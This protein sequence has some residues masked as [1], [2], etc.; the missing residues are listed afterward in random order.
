MPK[1]KTPEIPEIDLISMAI[2]YR[3]QGHDYI[4]I[5]EAMSADTENVGRKITVEYATELV[6]KGLNALYRE[7]AK[8]AIL[9]DLQRVNQMMTTAY[10][11]AAQGESHS[12][13][14]MLKLMDRRAK[15]EA[16]LVPQQVKTDELVASIKIEARGRGRPQHV[17]TETTRLMVEAFAISGAPQTIMAKR[18][19]I[20]VD[21]LTKHYADVLEYGE[22]VLIADAV[23]QLAQS[24]R[25][26]REASVFF[27]LKTRARWRETNAHEISGP[28]GTPLPAGTAFS[29]L[30]LVQLCFVDEGDI[31]DGPPPK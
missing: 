6:T 19:G 9:L 16:L 25:R 26:G 7:P 17:P 15:L 11:N 14:T 12:I 30:P 22:Q 24:V 2:D 4:Q 10:A 28:D 23:G 18:L 13:D 8:E 1:K 21:T 29:A 5:A 20:S 3:L 31:P 27:T